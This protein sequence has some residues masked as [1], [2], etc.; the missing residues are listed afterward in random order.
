[1]VMFNYCTSSCTSSVY[2]EALYEDHE[3]FL[4]D[5]FMLIDGKA[6]SY[7]MVVLFCSE[8]YGSILM[9][10]IWFDLFLERKNVME[11]EI[12]LPYAATEHDSRGNATRCTFLFCVRISFCFEPKKGNQQGCKIVTFHIVVLLIESTLL[13]FD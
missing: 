4:L 7:D 8:T 5:Y 2:Q 12:R 1:M 3:D 10:V 13:S 6:E 11:C 9:N